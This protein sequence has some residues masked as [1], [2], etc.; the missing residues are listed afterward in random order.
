MNLPHI[1]TL[2]LTYDEFDPAAPLY[3]DDAELTCPYE[4]SPLMPC[5]L[6]EPCGCDPVGYEQ[7]EWQECQRSSGADPVVWHPDS[8]PCPW[9]ASGEHR[10]IEGLPNRPVA[11]CWITDGEDEV[12]DL[13]RRRGWG[14]GVYAVRVWWDGDWIGVELWESTREMAS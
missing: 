4:Q 2:K 14:P 8:G 12:G 5:A 13:A 10:Y 6:W 3:T 1:L 7:S 11:K 9:S